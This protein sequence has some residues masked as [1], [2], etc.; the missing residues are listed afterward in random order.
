MDQVREARGFLTKTICS[1]L[2]ESTDALGV[3]YLPKFHA[4]PRLGKVRAEFRNHANKFRG[5]LHLVLA[6]G[7]FKIGIRTMSDPGLPAVSEL[8][9]K[10]S[11]PA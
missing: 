10:F 2:P 9:E 5:E 7:S 3:S 8:S 11:R 6:S 4:R 1:N